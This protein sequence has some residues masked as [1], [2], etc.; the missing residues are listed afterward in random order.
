[1]DIY[2]TQYIKKAFNLVQAGRYWA[3]DIEIDIL[4]KD[5]NGS[6]LCKIKF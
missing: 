5:N 6:Q 2:S 4:G 3:K 1:M